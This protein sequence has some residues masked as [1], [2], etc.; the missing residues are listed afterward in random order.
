MPRSEH[1]GQRCT[2]SSLGVN[3]SLAPQA[4]S[5]LCQATWLSPGL[6]SPAPPDTAAHT[7]WVAV[8]SLL[9]QLPPASPQGKEGL[10]LPRGEERLFPVHG[11]LGE[12]LNTG[13]GEWKDQGGRA[14]RGGLRKAHGV[15]P[16]RPR[17]SLAKADQYPHS[18]KPAFRAK[19]IGYPSNRP[20][21]GEA[22]PTAWF[23]GCV[24]S[25]P[26][27]GT[28]APRPRPNPASPNPPGA[29]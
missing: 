21:I 17:R 27:L 11:E 20:T 25:T 22:E 8:N 7:C 1:R 19:V 13:C 14:A 26:S 23:R 28:G 10:I 5:S 15:H 24:G 18:E 6:P 16:A 9:A 2:L 12:R 29:R 3:E 4:A